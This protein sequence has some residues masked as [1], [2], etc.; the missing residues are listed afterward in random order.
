MAARRFVQTFNDLQ[1]GGLACA[2]GPEQAEY[3]AFFNDK[4]NIIHGAEGAFCLPRQRIF[5]DEIF[6]FNDWHKAKK[7]IEEIERVVEGDPGRF[8]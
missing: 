2:V 6:Y 1:R 5:F 3:L 7:S 4:G 8:L